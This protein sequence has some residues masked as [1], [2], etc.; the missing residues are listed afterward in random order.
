MSLNRNGQVTIVFH[1]IVHFIPILNMN[2]GPPDVVQH[3][4][5]DCRG[6]VQVDDDPALMTPLNCIVLE[7]A[8][9]TIRH[10]KWRQYFPSMPG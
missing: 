5:L 7:Q 10:Q 4:A 2:S 6:V 9:W 8:S 1:G 3:V